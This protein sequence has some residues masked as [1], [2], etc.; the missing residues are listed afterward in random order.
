[1]YSTGDGDGKNDGWSLNKIAVFT[2]GE[3]CEFNWNGCSGVLDSEI[4]AVNQK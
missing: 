3:S 1:M 2:L 4:V